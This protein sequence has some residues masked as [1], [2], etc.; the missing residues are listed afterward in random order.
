MMTKILPTPKRLSIRWV[1]LIAV[2]LVAVAMAYLLTRTPSPAPAAH[3]HT[4]ATAPVTDSARTVMLSPASA[5]KIGVTYATVALTALTN[6]IR[7]VAQVTVDETRIKIVSPK[8]DGWIETI[9][10]SYTGQS[11]AAGAPLLTVYSPMFVT[12]QEEFLLAE[13][14]SRS[15][16]AAAEDARRRAAD[17][18]ASSRSRLAYLGASATDIDNLERSGAV[19][20]TMVVRS[21][22]SGFVVEKNALQGQRIMA[23]DAMYKIADISSVWVEGEIYEQDLR[24][25]RLG[26]TATVELQAFP[27]EVFHGT[28]AYVYPTL[29]PDTRTARVR[30]RLANESRRL[31]PGMYATM[32]LTVAEGPNRLSV[33]RTAILSTGERHLVFVKRSDGML[34]PRD[35]SIGITT[36]DRIEILRGLAAGETVVSSATFLV[37]AESNLGTALGGMGNMPGMDIAAP[38]KE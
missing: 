9:P 24:F 18:V 32:R 15:L 36:T 8:V 5:Q 12:A 19:Q 29:N 28:V 34:E 22:A 1:I 37:D 17:L 25:I 26:Q 20:R 23:G 14:L 13:S 31:M 21:P 16:G 6:E 11:V 38:K 4:Q 7:S 27:G 30:V 33:P 3:A 10:V 2:P 35:V